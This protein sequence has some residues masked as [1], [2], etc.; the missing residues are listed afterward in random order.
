[1]KRIDALKVMAEI[2][3]DLPVIVTC[4]ATSRELAAIADAPNHLYLL[5]SMG[6]TSSVGLGLALALDDTPHE[7]VLVIDGDGSLLMNLGSLATIGYHRPKKLILGILDN[8]TYA[9]TAG[10]ATYAER[11]DLGAIAASCGIEVTVANT[12]ESVR[13]S[14]QTTLF[15]TG[16]QVLHIRIEPGNAANVPLLLMDP[17]VLAAR[18]RSW[19]D[20]SHPI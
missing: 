17:V 7:H 1:V 11:I 4:A 8:G 10:F 14:L 20:T 19:L 3:R 12:E 6:L 5:D 18:F 13:S 16:P 2:A 15:R 9:S